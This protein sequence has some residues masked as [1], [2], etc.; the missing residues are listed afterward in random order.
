MQFPFTWDP[1]VLQFDSVENFN[2]PNLPQVNFNGANPG[3][4]L[5]VWADPNGV[6]E[7]L[8]DGTVIFSITFT[9]LTN[10]FATVQIDPNHPSLLFEI[11]SISNNTA[12][13]YSAQDVT[14]KP[15]LI[16]GQVTQLSGNIFRDGNMNCMS[17]AGEE[18]L[19]NWILAIE[20]NN[21][22]FYTST[23]TDGDYAIY[24]DSGDYVITPQ[25]SNSY[26]QLCQ[27]NFPTTLDGVNDVTQDIAVQPIVSCPFMDV[28]IS[29]LFLRRCFESKYNVSY[30]NF[31]TI[32]ADD[33]YVEVELDDFL[34][35][36]STSI[37]IT[38]QTGN[39]ITLDLGDVAVGECGDFE[40]IVMVSC[41]ADLGV[42]HCS[43]A[44]IF[45]NV[46]CDPLTGWSGAD[47]QI[48]GNCNPTNDEVEFTITNIGSGDMLDA[49]TSIV[50]E[51]AVMLLTAPNI[52]TLTTNES[53]TISF[54]ANGSTV[55]MEVEQVE[56]HPFGGKVIAVVEGC[57]LN[58]TGGFSTGFVNQFPIENNNTFTAIDCRGNI[59]AFDP[60]DKQAFPRGFDNS[61][62]IN[63]NTDIEYQIR[64]QN[65]GTDTAFN[66][67]VRDTLSELLDVGSFRMGA[68]SHA[69]E[70][71]MEGEGVVVFNF[72]N[73]M[74]PDSNINE[75]ASHGY[76]Q[77][78]I[79]QKNDLPLGSIIENEAAIFFDFNEPII[80]NTVTHTIGEDFISVNTQ[81]LFL[82]NTTVRTFPNPFED[83][84]QFEI[85][86][87]D[88]DLLQLNIYD[89]TGRL[90][91][92]ATYSDNQFSVHRNQ[93]LSGMYIYTLSGD[94]ELISS[95][96]L[97]VK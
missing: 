20:G 74:L 67:V 77:F 53:Q 49:T 89:L 4:L 26:W 37:P 52:N 33:A 31:G 75:P 90:I 92:T 48:S 38:S 14:L 24:L 17:D 16:N 96:K 62:F 71:E 27:N 3:L 82:P 29:A 34:S 23:N 15:G 86:G 70:F 43:S 19:S 76:I 11:T 8:A 13:V 65:T 41:D 47:L 58:G 1:N 78:S 73:I 50:I 88:F 46:I 57:G 68:S 94:G 95:G 6:G 12:T 7:T 85:E 44:S 22:I 36:V 91:R 59:G 64:F 87:V 42:T 72:N 61:N 45:P 80:T 54:A 39:T 60:N 69:V 10:D 81:K 93:L 83:V 35:V 18:G 32:T 63:V 30:C 21:H 25:V 9:P 55:R 79:S 28:D 40:I 84:V 56:N 51:D 66:V 2:L 5:F 97:S